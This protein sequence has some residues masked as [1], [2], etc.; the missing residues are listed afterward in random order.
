MRQIDKPDEQ[1]G[2][3]APLNRAPDGPKPIHG[4]PNWIMQGGVPYYVEPI[5]PPAPAAPLPELELS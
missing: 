1:T 3:G 2:L 5:K 4:R